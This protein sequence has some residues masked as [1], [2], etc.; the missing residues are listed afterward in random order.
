MDQRVSN[1]AFGLSKSDTA[2]SASIGFHTLSSR[3]VGTRG[4]SDDLPYRTYLRWFQKTLTFASNRASIK[5]VLLA[6]H[7]LGTTGT[8][9]QTH[10]ILAGFD[11]TVSVF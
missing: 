1:L 9:S 6:G 5:P 8:G 10:L 3:N 4:Q 11:T 2:A 7:T